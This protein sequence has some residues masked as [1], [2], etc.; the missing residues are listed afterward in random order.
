MLTAAP[1]PVR[2]AGRVGPDDRRTAA[3]LIEATEPVAYAVSRPDPL[4]VLVDLRNVNVGD[5]AN[6][7]RAAASISG[8]TLEQAT[9]IDGKSLARVRVAL[10][11]PDELPR[12]Q[13]AQHDSPRARGRRA[14]PVHDEGTPAAV[15][16]AAG[17]APAT[18][19]SAPMP[20]APSRPRSSNRSAPS[21]R[22]RPRRS[23]LSGNGRLD[24]SSL[25]ESDDQPRRLVLDF[26]NV[27]SKAP[28]QTGVDG[29]F[30]K[31]V[32]VA[33]EQP[34]AAGHARRDGV[35]PTAAYH[36]ERAGT[37]GR[38][39]AV[40]FDGR[41]LGARSW[42]HRRR[43]ATRRARTTEADI[44]L[45][46]A[47]A[48]AAP[49][50]APDPMTALTQAPAAEA[51]RR[52]GR[53]APSRRRQRRR[54]RRARQP[55]AETAPTDAAAPAAAA[56]PAARSRRRSRPS[57]QPTREH[58][59]AGNRAEEVHRQS[60]QLDFQ[61]ADLRSVLRNFA[62]ISG[63]NMIIDPQVQG[64][65][66]MVLNDVPWDQALDTILRAQQA[67]L[68]R[69]RQRSSASRR[70]RCSPTSRRSSAS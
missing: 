61:D 38:D 16:P 52:Q 26:P 4:T 39:L 37:D 50:A 63:L 67:R 15:K 36:V 14:A 54:F 20:R 28:A 41:K 24:P 5:A 62:E 18:T 21:T 11:S 13:R 53:R 49:L 45:A 7:W 22:A 70:W 29:A 34:R 56:P 17:R 27:S 43:F 46:V 30:V 66:D 1:A 25:T 10:A 40:V 60:D 33:L 55:S 69:R 32:R 57:A 31:Q 51:P 65:V 58:A 35:S 47:I 19:A 6:R 23:R 68:H 42:S 64:R 48:N 2:L 59:A 12:A 8:V 3:L 44:P 9:P